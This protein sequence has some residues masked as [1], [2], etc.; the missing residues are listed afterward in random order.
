[1]PDPLAWLAEE[2]NQRV[3]LGLNRSLVAYGP[4]PAQAHSRDGIELIDFS[5]NDY[6]G[7]ARDPRV[8]A[9]AQRVADQF[10]WGAGASALVSGWRSI[11]AQLAHE[12]A[13]FEQMEAAVLFPTGFAANAGTIAALVGAGDAVYLDRLNHACLVAGAKLSGARLRVY[14]H[15]D[16]A[17][18]AEILERER[19]HYRRVLIATDSVFSMDGDLAP[20]ADLVLIAERFGA[21]LMVDEAHGTGVYGPDGRG[22][23]SEAGVAERVPVRVGTLSKALGSIGGFVVGSRLLIDHLINRAPTLIYSTA[24]PPAAVAAALEALRIVQVEPWR[25]ER[26]RT[27]GRRVRDA[28]RAAGFETGPTDGPIVPVIVG[29]SG[30]AMEL[31]RELRSTGFLVPAIRPPT[32]PRG[33]ARLRI[34]VSAAHTD[35]QIDALITSW[36]LRAI[37]ANR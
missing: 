11:H 7:L 2:A 20:L 4:A 29:E 17:R 35:E 6:L 37:E 3:R 30:K 19:S 26:A 16:A 25:R 34:S 31:A 18:L 33:T 15:A 8:V 10:G 22:G 13:T 21:M 27:L 24:L 1:M 23:A 14:P 28:A 12:L 5:S 9:A 36:K 32:V